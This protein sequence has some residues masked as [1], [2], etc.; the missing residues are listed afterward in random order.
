[1][2]DDDGS[3]DAT[4]TTTAVV[5]AL[6]VRSDERIHDVRA[7]DDMSASDGEFSV[8][9]VT[10][11]VVRKLDEETV[12]ADV[13]WQLLDLKSLEGRPTQEALVG[14]S[15][16][17][18]VL[19]DVLVGVAR[20]HRLLLQSG[21]LSRGV[22]ANGFMRRPVRSLAILRAVL[23]GHAASAKSEFGP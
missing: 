13:G 19:R 17:P 12:L 4:H 5:A 16:P 7:W 11:A 8:C 1:L 20:A 22:L 9:L 18:K 14:G 10:A 15:E 23:C 2:D 6:D 3:T 21:N